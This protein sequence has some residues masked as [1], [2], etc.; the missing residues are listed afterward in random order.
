MSSV[1]SSSTT[2]NASTSIDATIESRV[3]QLMAQVDSST[4]DDSD[5][6]DGVKQM[7][8]DLEN[9]LPENEDAELS[10]DA[11]NEL[12]ERMENN[13]QS[14][15][16]PYLLKPVKKMV[17]KNKKV[18]LLPSVAANPFETSIDG[19]VLLNV[20]QSNH[21]SPNTQKIRDYAVRCYRQWLDEMKAKD[22]LFAKYQPQYYP[23]KKA[24][25]LLFILAMRINENYAYKTVRDVF[26]NS[27]CNEVRDKNY[28]GNPKKEYGDSIRKV[29]RFLLRK[30]GNQVDKV[31][32]LLNH[33]RKLLRSKL[34]KNLL[35]DARADVLFSFCRSS[36]LRGDSFQHMKL[37]DLTFQKITNSRGISTLVVSLS[38]WKDKF[39]LDEPRC[40]TLYGCGNHQECGNMSLLWYLSHWRKV[41]EK[42]NDPD[43]I[44]TSGDFKIKENCLQEPL[45][46]AINTDEDATPKDISN[47]IKN[48]AKK[49]LGK[50]YSFRSLR[51]GCVCQVFI[52]S[53][54]RSGH[55]THETKQAVKLH[56]G[57]LQDTAMDYYVRVAA[58][59][60][61]NVLALQQ[62]TDYDDG[63]DNVLTLV[64]QDSN[65]L[66]E[67]STSTSNIGS[68]ST[69]V[70][71]I[72]SDQIG[73]RYVPK[74]VSA[75]VPKAMKKLI[76]EEINPVLGTDMV[77]E[78]Q[79]HKLKKEK[80]PGKVW[81]NFWKNLLYKYTD[82]HLHLL[83]GDQEIAKLKKVMK[84]SK[85]PAYEEARSKYRSKSKT[86]AQSDIVQKFKN[87]DTKWIRAYCYRARRTGVPDPE[88]RVKK[89]TFV[90]KDE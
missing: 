2:P 51:S 83:E 8:K 11:Y 30:F 71:P 21:L 67:S 64:R 78:K 31:Q 57:W 48:Y 50:R 56:V 88:V 34:D 27:L 5:Y 61:Q 63:V 24:S 73:K 70:A 43:I 35:N 45:F 44:W 33:D 85:G 17:K 62:S 69:S 26:A 66:L 7:K 40:Q 12:L 32:P 3:D 46:K 39:V 13:G 55:V 22:E 20:A 86:Y 59:K 79:K 75:R 41:F 84:Q 54:L 90:K 81:S 87:G 16:A 4:A 28:G 36:G 80:N 74:T 15:S 49:H 65:E 53:I 60:Y 47:T 77:M 1:A 10:E 18:D 14:S 82:E 68:S 89:I 72:M 25:F 23:I 6:V 52:N 76:T 29:L 19:L 58:Y 38:I 9:T 37:K 42:S